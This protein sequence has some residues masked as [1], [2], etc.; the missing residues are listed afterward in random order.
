MLQNSGR[1]RR[2]PPMT[3]WEAGQILVDCNDHLFEK[4]FELKVNGYPEL[5]E[6]L[7]GIKRQI[8]DLFNQFGSHNFGLPGTICARE[9]LTDSEK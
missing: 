9:P 7:D 1:G 8:G 5:S 4:C 2:Q 6:K 3:D